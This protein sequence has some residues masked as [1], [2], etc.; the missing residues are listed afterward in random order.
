MKK[1]PTFAFLGEVGADAYVGEIL[2]SESGDPLGILALVHDTPVVDF[3]PFQTL[4]RQLAPRAGA[5]L[6]RRQRENAMRRSETRFRLLAEHSRDI[7]FY[8]RLQPS[9]SFDYIS[10]AV[11]AITGY[12]PEAFHA[13]PEVALQMIDEEDRPR[14]SAAMHASTDEPVQARVWRPDGEM[15]WLE[16]RLFA[17]RDKDERLVAMGGAIRDITPRMKAEEA[18]RLNEQYMRAL[19]EAIPDT[20]FRFDAEGT[21]LDFVPG[22]AMRELPGSPRG[23]AGRNISEL[24]PSAFSSRAKRLIQIALRSGQ[25]QRVE[26]EVA[27]GAQ[28]RYFEVLCLPFGRDEALLILRDFT[29]IKWHEGEEDRRRLRD[30]IDQKVEQQIR[31][32]P[33][34]LTYRELAILHLVA[35]GSADK[36]IAESLGISIYTVN[37]HVGNILGKMNAASRTEAGVRAI[38]EGLLG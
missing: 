37:K 29:A 5:E 17:F 23:S 31:V 30:E 33:Y 19:V 8:Y 32:N 38:R 35:D 28:S 22:E 7:L 13:D 20:I 16:Y 24:M 25:L 18:L 36:Q 21:L 12:P 9:P 15:R 6:E 1:F 34:G 4:L 27:T 3:G 14:V 2:R 10:P 26:F 11:E